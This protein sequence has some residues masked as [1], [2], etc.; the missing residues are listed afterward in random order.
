MVDLGPS[1]EKALDLAHRLTQ[2]CPEIQQHFLP[3]DTAAFVRSV[4]T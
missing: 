3:P 2:G 4:L 1:A